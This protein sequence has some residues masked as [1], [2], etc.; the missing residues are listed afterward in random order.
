MPAPDAGRLVANESWA[1]GAANALAHGHRGGNDSQMTPASLPPS[2]VKAVC[3]AAKSTADPR[4]S[5]PTQLADCEA[6]AAREGYEV[7]A[8]YSDEA[9]SAFKQDRGQGLEFALTHAERIAKQEGAAALIVQHSD[10]LARG[11]GKVAKHVV[12]YALWALKRN[13]VIRS[14]Q[15]D[16]TFSDLLYAVVTGQRNH[17][18]SARK[19]AAT[20]A[21]KRRSAERGEPQFGITPDG[22]LITKEF[23][24]NGVVIRTMDFDP[25]RAP[26]YHLIWKLAGESHG[27]NSI[28]EELDKHGYITSPRKSAHLPRPFDASRVRQ[29]LDN[30]TYAGLVVY[31]GEVIGE[32][33]WPA[34]VSPTEFE[35][36]R[37]ERASRSHVEQRRIGRPPEGYVLATVARCGKCRAPMD[38]V[39]SRNYRADGS[40]A[41]RYTCRTHRERPHDC[42]AKPIDASLVDHCF[43]SN[44]TTFLGDVQGWHDKLLSSKAAERVRLLEEADRAVTAHETA[45]STLGK[46]EIRYAKALAADDQGRAEAIEGAMNTQRA[47]VSRSELRLRATHDA[48][49]AM[50]ETQGFDD[51]LDFFNRLRTALTERTNQAADDIKRVNL[52]VR[53]F[54]A[55]V[56]L[57]AKPDG[58]LVEPHLSR[59]AVAR[60]VAG[61]EH[62]PLSLHHALYD[63]EAVL[64][65]DEMPPLKALSAPRTNAPSDSW[66]GVSSWWAFPSFVA[67]PQ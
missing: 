11:D 41:K 28:V 33:N 36:L 21:G 66:T 32:G 45:V 34:F 10:R 25:E 2:P 7:V 39:T 37:R 46:M 59:A 53:D 15:D 40:R 63:P 13:V 20:R 30:A 44:L 4:G 47:E 12:E 65:D 24:S 14:D 1:S 52:V 62:G 6:L 58:I 35:R 17:E 56:M 64:A 27:V 18:D 29:T 19:S 26:I 57:T 8:R 50:D 38:A 16:Q 23:A 51:L 5:I 61:Y 42:A 55:R 48:L 60:I 54:F 9:A 49:E 31:K 67:E 43:L 22:Y 3:Y